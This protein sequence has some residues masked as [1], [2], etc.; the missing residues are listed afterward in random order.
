MKLS[1]PLEPGR[2]N[3]PQAGPEGRGGRALAQHLPAPPAATHQGLSQGAPLL[4]C[5][6]VQ[7]TSFPTPQTAPLKNG[8]ESHDL[9]SAVGIKAPTYT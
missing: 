6:P 9:T 4:H 5:L 8:G 1:R 3:A 2:R 7:V